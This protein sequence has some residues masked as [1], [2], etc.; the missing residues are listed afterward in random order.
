MPKSLT[1]ATAGGGSGVM[2]VEVPTTVT[3]PPSLSDPATV[4][5]TITVTVAIA[6]PFRVP[7][8]QVTVPLVEGQLV[9]PG[10]LLAETNVAPVDGRRSVKIIPVVRSPLFVIL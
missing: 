3:F 1:V 9:W 4:G 6:P 10:E 8:V 7:T 5:A 2:V